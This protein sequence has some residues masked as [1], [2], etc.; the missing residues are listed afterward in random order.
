MTLKYIA[1]Q[2]HLLQKGKGKGK[3]KEL[4]RAI[5]VKQ[6]IRHLI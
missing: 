5:A 4:A 6:K 3:G 1:F 2:C